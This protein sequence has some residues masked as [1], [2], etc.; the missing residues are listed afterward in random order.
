MPENE[1]PPARRVVVHFRKYTVVSSGM[2]KTIS[3]AELSITVKPV[4]LV[5]G[6]FCCFPIYNHLRGSHRNCL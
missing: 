5:D 6:D 3:E 1:Q 2:G 4:F